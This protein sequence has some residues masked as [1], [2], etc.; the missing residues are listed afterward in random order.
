MRHRKK[1][2]RASTKP[3]ELPPK[4]KDRRGA[5]VEKVEHSET[6]RKGELRL[7]KTR[8]TFF[9]ELGEGPSYTSAESEDG[10]LVR[11][12]L[13]WHLAK[14]TADQILEWIPVVQINPDDE[15]RRY[16]RDDETDNAK[17]ARCA[18]AIERFFLALTNDGT[19]W[20]VLTWEEASD[21]SPTQLDDADRFVASKKYRDGPKAVK[22]SRFHDEKRFTLPYFEKGGST[23]LR[24]TPELW[25]GLLA[26]VERVDETR[27]QLRRI[28]SDKQGVAS[29]EAL[30]AGNGPLLL[31]SGTPT[32][33]KR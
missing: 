3:P 14:T 10:R 15:S 17:S 6:K 22:T 26:I 4:R 7:D 16:D 25:A 1:E 13:M 33:G 19:E 27:K 20:R 9:A 11:D 23:F 2:R 21:D 18:V 24:Y 30:G 29:I 32:K 31:G 28:I 8:M 12:W 5:I